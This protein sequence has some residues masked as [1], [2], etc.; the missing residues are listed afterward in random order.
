MASRNNPVLTRGPILTGKNY[1]VWSIKM[2]NFLTFEDCW[3][4]IVNGFKEPNL[5]DLQAMTN[6]QRNALGELGKKENK[7]LWLIQQGL[8][9]YC[10]SLQ[11]ILSCP[12][13]R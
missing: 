10:R 2:K 1:D 13:K 8:E 4:A 3:D 12:T 9:E 5:I 11:Q 6:A 7:A